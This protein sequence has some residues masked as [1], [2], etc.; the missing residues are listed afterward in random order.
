M[1]RPTL[2]QLIREAARKAEEERDFDNQVARVTATA[3]SQIAPALGR[4]I[5]TAKMSELWRGSSRRV[6]NR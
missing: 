1:N 4:N 5:T 2:A 3:V 6:E